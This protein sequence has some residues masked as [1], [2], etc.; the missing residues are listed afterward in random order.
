MYCRGLSNKTMYRNV[1]SIAPFL[2]ACK[3]YH[4]DETPNKR[5]EN[6]KEM[7]K[8]ECIRVKVFQGQN[9]GFIE[10]NK[11]LGLIREHEQSHLLRKSEQVFLH[12]VS[13]QTRV[14]PFH[15]HP[16]HMKQ[17]PRLFLHLQR[18]DNIPWNL[19]HW[20]EHRIPQ[21]PSEE[22][23]IAESVAPHLHQALTV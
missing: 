18:R 15:I 23:C 6:Q 7:N 16:S 21:E 19:H 1:S 9:S 2:Q 12:S 5:P 3:I 22:S 11:N 10:E 8:Q 17:L 13:S 20:T 14:G 4:D